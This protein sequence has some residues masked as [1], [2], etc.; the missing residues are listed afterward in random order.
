M[1]KRLTIAALLIT[2]AFADPSFEEVRKLGDQALARKD[3]ATA[4]RE[5]ER[6]VY[7]YGSRPDAYNAL[8]YACFLDKRYEKAIIQFKQALYF[9]R[10]HPAAQNNLMLA[11]GKRATEQTQELEFSEAINLL[12]ST[13]KQY[14]NH[15]QSLVLHY[16]QGQLEFFRGNE[17][18]GLKAWE[19]VAQRA[20]SSGTA[21]F[22]QAHTLYAHGKPKQALPVMQAALAKLPKEPVVRNYLALILSE[23]G[24]NKEAVAQLQKAEQSNVPYVD[25]FLNQAKILLKM[26]DLEGATAQVIKAR[27]LRPDYASVHLWL[28]AL[29]RQS[30][31]N[32][33]SRKEVGLALA[34]ENP[35]ALL[36]S[37]EIGKSVWLD[38]DYLGVSPVGAFVKPGKH[39]LKVLAKGQ[40]PALSEV[41]LGADQVAYASMSPTLQV[42]TE[43]VSQAV[44]SQRA[45]HSFALRDQGN[46]YWR[47]FQHFHTRPVVLLF[48]K[49]GDSSNDATLNALSELGSRF[50][51]RIGCAVIHTDTDKKNQA[52]SQMMSLPATYARLFDDGSVTRHYGL[53][54][55]QLPAVLV[56]DLDGYI[57]SQGQGVEGVAKAREALD[58]M[59]K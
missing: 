47:S 15:S 2:C 44:P 46:R 1:L 38:T 29:H 39:K 49:V 3:Y 34:D 7:L 55:D 28:A 8:G 58:S 41:T 40:P 52:I 11:V 20:P 59:V 9:D 13:E 37:G 57:A 16:A 22:V 18:A 48:W 54:A 19:S 23:L 53:S 42:E 10:N 36:V 21:K 17:A 27:D 25:L 56:V 31:N 32:E 30:G 50:G 43:S 24:K 51:T 6:L 4:I 35:P 14:P 5:F 45:A 12:A 33:G 26:G